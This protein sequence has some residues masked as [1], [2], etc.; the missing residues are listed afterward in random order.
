MSRKIALS[1]DCLDAARLV[2]DLIGLLQGL[3]LSDILTIERKQNEESL[4]S[5]LSLN[6]G[7]IHSGA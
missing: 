4:G 5:G 2:N 6:E 3:M 1:L 7:G